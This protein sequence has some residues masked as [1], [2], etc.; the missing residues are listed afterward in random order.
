MKNLKNQ[1]APVSVALAALL[2]AGNAWAASGN[3]KAT[4]T[5]NIG[6]VDWDAA[7][8]TGDTGTFDNSK[9]AI[10]PTQLSTMDLGSANISILAL[11]FKNNLQGPWTIGSSGNYFLQ[12]NQNST[13]YRGGATP[14]TSIDL[15]SVNQNGIFNCPLVI[16]GNVGANNQQFNVANT[17]SLTF[18]KN[19]TNG[20]NTFTLAGAGSYFFGGNI[21]STA[22]TA[23]RLTIAQVS[24]IVELGQIDPEVVITPSAFVNRVVRVTGATSA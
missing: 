23:A 8:G 1:I 3:K 20:A 13:Y 18:N 4:G 11:V 10:T 7:M 17:Y 5:M 14:N 6:T 15:S 12:L 9:F 2:I 19:I 16:G 21:V 24:E 22:P